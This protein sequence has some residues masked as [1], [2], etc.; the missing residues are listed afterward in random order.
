M[1]KVLLPND[2]DL[3]IIN[4]DGYNPYILGSRRQSDIDV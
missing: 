3:I 4:V 1:V 2:V